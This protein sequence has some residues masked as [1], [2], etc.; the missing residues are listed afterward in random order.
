MSVTRNRRIS[1][2]SPKDLKEVKFFDEE[3]MPD[4]PPKGARVKVSK[5]LLALFHDFC[6]PYFH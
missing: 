5:L 6:L 2:G 4:V 3:P 1:L